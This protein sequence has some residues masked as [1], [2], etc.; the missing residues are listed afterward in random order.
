MAM[1]EEDFWL[2]KVHITHWLHKVHYV[3]NFIN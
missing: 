1:P 2:P 3:T